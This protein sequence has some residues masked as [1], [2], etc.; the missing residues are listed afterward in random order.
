[1]SAGLTPAVRWSGLAAAGVLGAA[2]GT[3][4]GVVALLRRDRP[5]HAVGRTSHARVEPV[6]AAEP[7]G[8]LWIDTLGPRDVL[9]RFSRGA[10]LPPWA[11]DVQGVAVRL[12]EPRGHTD[13]LFG[14]TGMRGPGRF[15]LVPRRSPLA[16]PASSLMP[17]RGPDGPLLLAVEPLPTPAA[18]VA[19]AAGAAPAGARSLTGTRWRLLWSGASG[20][21]SAFAELVVGP[22]A[23]PD[24]DRATRFD[25]LGATPP[26]LPPYRWA[27]ALRSPAYR[28]ARLVGRRSR[29]T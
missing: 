1:M 2:V 10:G 8:V 3:G 23:G 28:L 9:V 26:D 17:F 15:V 22:D 11:P 16:G 27:A 14:S 29:T 25:P 12:P 21:W 19:V 7:S 18:A 6:L 4:I 5:L 24:V 13:L 20:P